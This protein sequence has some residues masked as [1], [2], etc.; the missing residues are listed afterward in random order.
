MNRA[1]A[2]YLF[3]FNLVA[4]IVLVEQALIQKEQ[5]K[6]ELSSMRERVE[7]HVVDVTRKMTEERELARKENR[8][9][10]DDLNDKVTLMLMQ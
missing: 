5:L 8:A 10:R 9:E 6:E 7:Q 2:F 3:S 4:C 1:S